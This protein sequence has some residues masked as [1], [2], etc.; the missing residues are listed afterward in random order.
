MH[1]KFGRLLLSASAAAC[2]ALIAPALS[3]QSLPAQNSIQLFGPIDVRFSASTTGTGSSAVNFNSTTL[4]LNCAASPITAILSST[5]DSTGNV[6]VDNNI[7]LTVTR[8]ATSTGPTNLCKGGV[9]NSPDGPFQ[10]CFTLGYENAAS[11]QNLNGEDPDNFVSA[12]GVAPIDI[13]GSL[14]S[15]PVQVKI[16]LQ[17][18]GFY[19]ASSTL[20]LNTNCTQG[21]VTGPAVISGNPIPQT[22]PTPEQLSQGFPFNPLTNQQVELEYDLTLAQA[23]GTLTIADQTIPSVAD[24]P[25]DPALYQ[26]T[27]TPQT[28]FATSTCLIHSGELLPSGQA[29]CKLFTLTCTV[30]T[31]ST[32]TGAQ[33]PVSSLPNE[34]FRDN[35]DGPSFILPDISTPN[36]PTFHEGI[37]FLM[38]TEGWTGGPCSFDPAANL[39]DLP[40]PQ[41]LLSSFTGPGEYTGTGRTTHPNSTFIVI[42]QI[43]EDLTTVAV[44]GQQPGGWINKSIAT[45]T[46]SSQPPNLAGTNLT[47]AANFVAS[48]IQSITYGISTAKNVPVPG[49]PITSDTVLSNNIP[50]PTLANPGSP[51]T[52]FAPSPQTLSSLADGTYLLHYY[53]Q[54]CAGTLELKF[55]QGGGGSWFTSYYT[56]PINIDTVAPV[57]ASGPTL[58]PAPSSQG[59]YLQG[60]VVTASYRCTDSLSGVI[61]CGT[62]TYPPGTTPNTGTITTTVDTSSTGTKSFTVQA[63]DAARNTSS[64]TVTY[65]VVSPYDGQIHLSLGKSTVTY[66][67]GTTLTIAITPTIA[68]SSNVSAKK[69]TSRHSHAPSGTLTIL[70]GTKLLQTLRL[71]G[72]KAT[73]HLD[74]L[75]AG[76][77]SISAVYSGDTSTPG[78]TSAP[79]TLTVLPAPVSLDVKCS[80]PSLAYGQDYTCIVGALTP[81]GL[82]QGYITYSYDNAAP[83]KVPTFLGLALFSLHKPS[84]GSHTVVVSYPAQGSYLTAP[85][86]TEKFTVTTAPGNRH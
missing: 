46:L 71:A 65:Q 26:S 50:C 74:K 27:L 55:T 25:L 62:Q 31:G 13:S 24:M 43:P 52:E 17:D 18:E 38:A 81:N 42:A 15:G 54:D 29:G 5:P 21:G 6:L 83:V 69:Q 19:L 85:P 76:S 4:N 68:P 57:V 70:D 22:D 2:M 11:A 36:G 47:G 37:G 1:V 14:A 49:D 79:V 16:D 82:V 66:P 58:S 72:D 60:Q 44:A 56:F 78:G 35:F 33:C 77:H 34:V 51:A 67:G 41:N 8:G 80:N 3:A 45:V 64:S 75:A 86:R 84:I 73:A 7:N 32:A 40:C 53:A 12:W 23:A 39:Q 10:N 61:H 30:G 28:S 9:N 59:A 20:Y 48:P 63:I